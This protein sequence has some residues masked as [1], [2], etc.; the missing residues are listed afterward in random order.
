[1]SH[2]LITQIG[3]PK[4][5]ADNEYELTTYELN[6]VTFETAMISYGLAE[7]LK[8]DTLLLLGTTGSAWSKLIS[9]RPS[10][11]DSQSNLELHDKLEQQE[12][13]DGISNGDLGQ[14][15]LILSQ[16]LQCKVIC[17]ITP[18]LQ[19]DTIKE[20]AQYIHTMAQAV[21]PGDKITLDITHGLRHHPM[22][23]LVAAQYLRTTL[24]AEIQGIYYG[25]FER[26]SNN[27]TPIV[28]LEGMLN[29]IDWVTALSS[30][31]KDGDYSIF[32][33]LMKE[34]GVESTLANG[35]AKAGFFERSNNSVQARE[36]LSNYS[37]AEFSPE[38]TP[39][40]HLFEA[41][42]EKRVAW[43]QKPRRGHREIQLAKQYLD[44]RDY[45]RACIFAFEGSVSRSI[46]MGKSQLNDRKDREEHT[47]R[48][49]EYLEFRELKRL[50]NALAHGV[51]AA[52]E[53]TRNLLQEEE[54][55]KIEILRL[56]KKVEKL[57]QNR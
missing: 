46:E 14:L 44:R 30:F 50:R 4:E 36:Q 47:E 23:A 32:A 22:L 26:K 40:T 48:L 33:N 6:G 43:T 29:L 11:L 27:I 25:M 9:M 5:K 55:L 54:K 38:E 56:I 51:A 2:I 12:T 1:M 3:K 24:A 28:S 52:N 15:A 37:R 19:T 34:D 8:P 35:I 16:E 42:L 53:K 45:L 7:T 41:A 13:N 31:D 17:Q 49:S 57:H 20:T 39:L 21:E 18:Y 10:L